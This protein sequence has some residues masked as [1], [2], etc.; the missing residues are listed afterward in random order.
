MREVDRQIKDLEGKLASLAPAQDERTEVKIFVNAGA[1]LEAEIA[2]RYQVGAASWVPFYDARLATGTKAEAPKLQ[3]VRR[4]SIQQRSGESWDDVALA[5]STARPGAGTAAPELQP[6]TVDYE[7]DPQRP[8]PPTAGAPMPRSIAQESAE[9]D[10]VAGAEDARR[11]TRAKSAPAPAPVQAEEVRAAVETQAFQAIYAIAGRV[12]VPATGEAKR[13]QIDEAQLEPALTVRTVPKREQKAF[14][15]AKVAMARGTPVL[16]GQVSLFRDGT[17]VGN[18]RLPLLAPGEEH[19]LGFGVDDSV[20]VRHTIAEEK[21]AETG[22]ITSS[23]TDTR[24]YRITVKNL[25]RA[26]DPGHRHR[27]D[28]GVAERRHQDRAAGQDGADQA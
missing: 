5:L 6:V 18:G 25:H 28:P 21:R 9:L 15:Y 24:S 4:A 17:F 1:A 11:A 22:I 7:P 12:T 2:I 27:P 23:K 13:V 8:L 3:L 10:R 19:E 20:R 16:P 26:G 14:L